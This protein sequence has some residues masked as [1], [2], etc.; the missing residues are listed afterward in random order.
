MKSE[1]APN[2][3]V[4]YELTM[5]ITNRIYNS[6]LLKSN[7]SDYAILYKQVTDMVRFSFLPFLAQNMMLNDV[8]PCLEDYDQIQLLSSAIIQHSYKTL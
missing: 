4:T 5:D 2:A 8:H 7:S 3:L 1:E 6:S